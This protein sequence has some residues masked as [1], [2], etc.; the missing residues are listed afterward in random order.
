MHRSVTGRIIAGTAMVLIALCGAAHASASLADAPAEMR[1]AVEDNA[2]GFLNDLSA[3]R[4]TTTLFPNPQLVFSGVQENFVNTSTGSM[5]FLVRDLVRVGGMPIV[6][7]RVYDSTLEEGGDFGPG[8]KLTVVE[9]VRQDGSQLLFTDA[10]NGVHGLDVSGDTVTPESPTTAPIISGSTRTTGGEAGIVVLESADGMLRRFK[11]DGDVWRLV[12]V[13]H[14]RGWVRLE[15]RRGTLTEVTSDAGWVRISRRDDGRISGITD[16]IGR[17]VGYSYDSDGRL[18]GVTDLAGE[19]WSLG[20]ASDDLLSSI[21][22]PRNKVVLA[23]AWT[24]TRVNRIRVLRETTDFAYA[25]NSTTATDAL[26]RDTVYRRG[27]SG[28]TDSITDR[29]GATTEVAFDAEHRPV[30]VT[31]DNATVA[32]IGYDRNGDLA[33]LWQTS[34]ETEFT[35]NNRGEVTVATGA[36]TARYRYSDRRVVHASDSGGHRDYRYS[37]AGSLSGAT[38]DGIDTAI[39]SNADGVLTELSRG[40]SSLAAYVYD[41]GGRVSSIDYGEGRT[42][43]FEYDARGFRTAAE[44]SYGSD[45]RVDANMSYDAAGNLTRMERGVEGDEA[46][47]HTYEIGDYNEVV[48]VRAGDGQ[49]A[50]RPDLTFEYDAAGRVQGSTLA[51]RLAAVEYDSLDRATRVTVDGETILERDYRPDDPDAAGQEDRRT[52]GVVVVAPVSPVF[53]TMESI[54]YSRPRSTEFGIVAYSPTR[55]TFEVRPDALAADALLLGS[56]HA[57][58]APL[59]GSEP[60]PAPFG[61]DKPSSSLF[62]PPEFRAVNCEVCV[63]SVLDVDLDVTP[64]GE[65]CYTTYTADVD[66]YCF[67]ALGVDSTILGDQHPWRHSTNFGDG[68]SA[69]LTTYSSVVSDSHKYTATGRYTMTHHVNCTCPSVFA[70]GGD[71]ETFNVPGGIWSCRPSPCTLDISV[72]PAAPAISSAPAMPT[73]TATANNVTPGHATVSWVARVAYTSSSGVCSGGPQFPSPSVSGHGTTFRP[74][75][76]GLYGGELTI[77]ATCSA[78]G[79]TNS[80]VSK[81][82]RVNGTQPDDLAIVAQLGSVGVPFDS[83]DLRRIGCLES[84]LT[85]FRPSPGPPY[86]GGGGDA[87]IMQICHRRTAADIWNWRSNIETGRSILNEANQK[88]ELYLENL[89]INGGADD[90]S[91]EMWR[92]EAIHR[93]NAGTGK[94]NEYWEWSPPKDDK[95]GQWIKVER[96][97][98]AGYVGYVLGKSASCL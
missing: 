32:R 15:W 72:E 60:N 39:Q 69:D 22:D 17:T 9:E 11:Q 91:D 95:P 78:L 25:G 33:T 45:D 68:Y 30:T 12:H 29:T 49:D 2:T 40:V 64:A 93:Y 90:F 88:A 5:T 71:S 75:F 47:E 41:S 51:S 84:S 38:I 77:T 7:G 56:L 18:T 26:G 76:A 67:D 52:G 3:R 43:S 35:T 96:G 97:G 36:W 66:G 58:M 86:M 92:K 19:S 31:R 27:D 70:H 85:Q 94:G 50:A 57:R 80:T 62:I 98:E 74:T 44:Y 28:I 81:T 16:D 34:G 10:S 24:D 83:A 48:R 89:K 4:R 23:A 21:T 1:E 73:V 54:V 82:V 8:W 6:M 63:G 65:Y 14:G 46:T 42:A 79:H 13:R 59:D 87:G 53:G 20:Y 61:H 37:D 55:R